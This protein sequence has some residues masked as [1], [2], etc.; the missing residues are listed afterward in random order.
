MK[1]AT[2]HIPIFLLLIASAAVAQNTVATSATPAAAPAPSPAAVP[3]ASPAASPA[4]GGIEVEAPADR[5]S[6]V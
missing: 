6:V 1:T 4:A 2:F 5:K 3:A